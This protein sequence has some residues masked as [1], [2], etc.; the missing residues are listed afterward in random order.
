MA[1]SAAYLARLA[2]LRA[3]C[4][5]VSLAGAR[6]L[7]DR[8]AHPPPGP[9]VAAPH[10]PRQHR[11]GASARVWACLRAAGQRVECVQQRPV[12]IR[13]QRRH[14]RRVT[15]GGRLG[16]VGLDSCLHRADQYLDV[17]VANMP[18]QP[19]GLDLGVPLLAEHRAKPLQLSRDV[20]A[21][22][23][24]DDGA[25]RSSEQL[26]G[27]AWAAT[28]MSCTASGSWRR[29][30]GSAAT[31]SAV[32]A[33][34]YS[35]TTS[36]ALGRAPSSPALL[37]VGRAST[38]SSLA[39]RAE[40]CSPASRRTLSAASSTSRPPP[41]SSTSTSRHAAGPA[42]CPAAGVARTSSSATSASDSPSAPSS[43]TVCR[44]V[45]MAAT[46]ASRSPRVLART[47]FANSAGTRWPDRPRG[48]AS[49]SRPG[50]CP[51]AKL[52]V[53]A[54]ASWPACA[55]AQR[56]A[57]PQQ[58]QVRGVVVLGFELL[59]LVDSPC[60]ADARQAVQPGQ[61]RVRLGLVLGLGFARHLLSVPSLAVDQGTLRGRG[62]HRVDA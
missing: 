50:C 33:R 61:L 25:E 28:L 7:P 47:R 39:D 16:G 24:A 19:A 60:G 54:A 2:A 18:L 3:A 26:R 4:S 53:P 9:P 31:S 22:C 43:V 23:R 32:C 13:V 40:R 38:R 15:G 46:G 30:S 55:P 36:A 44:T 14:D 57:G 42:P 49:S 11:A 51:P 6:W 41:V 17:S 58:S 52:Q 37:A 27:A 48:R 8:C 62:A 56:D 29:T 21:V 5:A 12:A 45:V 59:K 34:R 10:R 35:V 1:A 20:I